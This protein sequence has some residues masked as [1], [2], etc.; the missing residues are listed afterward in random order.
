M[1]WYKIMFGYIVKMFT[2]LL[3]ACATEN[4]GGLLAHGHIK[5]VSSNSSWC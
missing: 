5:C 3:S 4:I 1:T 2:G